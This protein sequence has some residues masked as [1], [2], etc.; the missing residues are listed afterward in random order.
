MFVSSS[1][2]A[3]IV[4]GAKIAVVMMAVESVSSSFSAIFFLFLFLVLL[5]IHLL[6]SSPTWMNERLPVHR[7]HPSPCP[8]MIEPSS[9]T[10]TLLSLGDLLLCETTTH[11]PGLT[12]YFDIIEM[13][14]IRIS[15]RNPRSFLVIP[16]V[17]SPVRA[18]LQ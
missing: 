13:F 3:V 4:V 1:F 11:V 10:L 8:D 17:H 5:C 6:G 12:S 14:P 15:Y 2:S 16:G 7:S 9:L 18:T